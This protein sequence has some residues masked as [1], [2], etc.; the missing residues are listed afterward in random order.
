MGYPGDKAG[1]PWGGPETFSSLEVVLSVAQEASGPS[2]SVRGLCEAL[3]EEGFE[4]VLS[5]QES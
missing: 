4:E 1:R 5:V 2:Y 3:T